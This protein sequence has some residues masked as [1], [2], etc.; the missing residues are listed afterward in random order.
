M[1]K[2][3]DNKLTRQQI[4]YDTNFT[5]KYLFTTVHFLRVAIKINLSLVILKILF[6]YDSH[7]RIQKKKHSYMEEIVLYFT[8]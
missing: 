1:K 3:L 2:K 7:S 8:V 5:H 4:K 6:I